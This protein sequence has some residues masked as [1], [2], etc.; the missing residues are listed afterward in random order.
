M[1]KI[2]VILLTLMLGNVGNAQLLTLPHGMD[3]KGV[4]HTIEEIPQYIAKERRLKFIGRD[5]LFDGGSTIAKFALMDGREFT[6][7]YA[8]PG[9]WTASAKAK[10]I[11]PVAILGD[12]KA[13]SLSEIK[14]GS[15][16]EA[17]I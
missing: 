3:P 17:H 11:Q 7:F 16:L 2:Y 6:L 4:V 5:S 10:S 9:Y 14:R 12:K 15:T 8:H 1:R 13:F